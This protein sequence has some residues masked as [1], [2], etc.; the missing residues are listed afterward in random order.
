M[1][2]EGFF[3]KKPVPRR[4]DLSSIESKK[5][6]RKCFR[7]PSQPVPVPHID[8]ATRTS[9]S[10][11]LAIGCCTLHNLMRIRYQAGLNAV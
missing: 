11:Y 4:A 2:N 1:A 7:D 6:R 10:S 5:N 3:K 9:D 8:D